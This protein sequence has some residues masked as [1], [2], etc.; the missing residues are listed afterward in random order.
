M[1][2]IAKLYNTSV[3]ELKTLNKLNT[4]ILQ[5][6]QVLKIPNNKTYIVKS[7]DS[8]WKI[9]K[10]NNTT[11]SDLIKLNNLKNTTLQIGQV[12]KIN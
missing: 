10:D 8:L 6:G 4:N 3:S 12:L 5:I 9:A 1:W 11:I 2:D 7:G